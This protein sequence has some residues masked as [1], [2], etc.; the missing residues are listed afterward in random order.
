MLFFLFFFNDTPATEISTYGHT[1]SLH[2]ALPICAAFRLPA[3]APSKP[4]Q[5]MASQRSST[6]GGSK[7][8]PT[9]SWQSLAT[10]F[11]ASAAKLI[12]L[13]TR[14]RKSPRLNSSH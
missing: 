5:A 2:D 9:A 3:P 6:A 11:G 4:C 8:A 10:A 13:R 7:S 1:L 12:A 14:D